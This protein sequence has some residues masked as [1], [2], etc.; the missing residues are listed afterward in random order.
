MYVIDVNTAFGKHIQFDHDL[1]LGTLLQS[2]DDHQ[3][4]CALSYSLRG[5]SYDHRTG[6][7]ETMAAAH[8]HP[9]I[10]P[11]AT[12]DPREYLG[13]EDEVGRC[14]KQGFRVFRF[15]PE[16]QRWSLSSTFFAKI[17]DRLRDRGVCLVFTVGGLNADWGPISEIAHL[18]ADCGLPVIL[19]DTSY[20]NM[21]EVMAVMHEYP[22]VYAE[23]NWLATV[24]GV[25]VMAG[26]V[27]VDRVLYG[28]STLM[29]PVQKS[30]NQVLETDL[31]D[32]DKA[33]I[34][35][36]NAMRLLGIS[37]EALAGRP[38]LTDMEP[39]GFEEPIVDVHSHL[40]YWHSPMPIENYDSTLM[41]RRMKQFGITHTILSSYEGMR[42]NIETANRDVAK[43]IEGHPELL[44]YV[45][46]N[47]HQ[48]QRSC[49]QMDKYYKMPNFVGAEI[50]L[51]HTVQPTGSDE[52]RALMAE[53]GK[54]GKPVLFMPASGA[55]ARAERE[56]GLQNPDLTII[57]AHSM[58]G[59]WARVIA[60]VPNICVEFCASKPSV[61]HIRECLAELGPERLLFGSD[62]TLLSVGASVGLYLDAGLNARERRLIL[63]KNARRAF[64]L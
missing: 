42:Y 24:G 30:L 53:V 35:G 62:Q 50:E 32:E 60:D 41:R 22:H 17:L 61:H 40:G 58:D 28:S 39:K 7:T 44:G 6:N 9:Q 23:T 36:G 64:K 21:A 51:S 12:L 1:S 16:E 25:E 45:E 8:A 10:I 43:A 2:L 46:L 34:L 19:T 37:P 33:A 13:W 49:A 20:G 56:L 15:F 29:N 14:L 54:R 3:V 57:H 59:N 18:T 31:S 5:V 48:L 26:E 38:E 27:G 63:C 11:V 4:A 47:P 52:V 55:D